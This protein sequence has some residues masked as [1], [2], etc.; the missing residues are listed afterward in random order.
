M[1]QAVDASEIASLRAKA[2]D[3]KESME[4]G[5]D[6]DSDWKN[7]WPEENVAPG[8]KSTMLDFYAVCAMDS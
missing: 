1:T 8:F 3:F 5:R 6:W 4:I 2:P 7:M